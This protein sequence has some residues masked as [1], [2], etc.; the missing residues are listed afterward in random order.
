LQNVKN[1][2]FDF[3]KKRKKKGTVAR[4]NETVRFG[5]SGENKTHALISLRK[6]CV[7]RK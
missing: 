4:I 3:K 6:R 5:F 7:L 2:S 1:K